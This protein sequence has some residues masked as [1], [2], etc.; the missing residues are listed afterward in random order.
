MRIVSYNTRG[1]RTGH[2]VADKSSRY[3]VDKLLNEC[4][5]LCLQETWLAKQDLDNLNS[6]HVDFHGAGESTTDLSTRIVRGRIPGGVAILWNVKYD[7]AVNV[8]RLNVDWAVGLEIDIDEKKFTILNVYMPYESNLLEDEFLH[9]LAFIKAYIEDSSSTCVFVMGDF[10]ADLS[11]D[12]SIFG[13]HLTSYC[14]ENNLTL[15]SKILLPD[16]SFTYISDAWHSTSWLDHCI[17]TADA[18][19]SLSNIEILYNLATSDHIPI[20]F[21]LNVANVPSLVAKDNNDLTD[22][23]D[24]SK[25]TNEDINKY[26]ATTDAQLQAVKLPRDALACCDPNCKNT[27]HCNEL[28]KLYE[29]IVKAVKDSSLCLQSRSLKSWTVKPGWND[30]VAEHHAAARDAFRLWHEAGK[31]R[32]GALFE[33]KKMTTARFKYSLRIIKRQENMMRADSLARGLQNNDYH[34]FW[35]EVNAMNNRKTSLPSNIEGV[36]GA[37]N[38][39][40]LWRKHYSDL[41]NSVKSHA[42]SID[43]VD[44]TDTM[45]I[46]A[47]DIQDAI[48]KIKEGKACGLDDITVEHLK[49][50]SFKLLPLLAM[51][52]TGFLTHGVLPDSV[53]SVVLIP[54]IKDKTASL[55]SLSNYRPIA[56]SSNISKILEYVLLTRLEVHLL[57]SEN[58]FGFKKSLGTDMCIYALQE[59]VG[60]Y[61]HLNTSVFLCFIDATKAFD[62]VNHLKLFQKLINRGVPKY[63]VRLLAFWYANQTMVV[64]WGNV[65]SE[66]FY[67]SNG[68]QQGGILSPFLFNV[69]IHDLSTNLNLCKT[70]CVV[71]CQTFNHLMYADD[72]VIFSPYSAGLQTLL[73]VCSDYGKDFDIKYNPSKSKVMIVRTK[74]DRN[75]NFPVLKLCGT[76]LEQTSSIK[77]LGRFITDDWRDDRDIQRQYCKL[78]AQANMLIRKFSACSLQVKCSLFRA[79]CTPLYTAPLWWNYGR[80]TFHKFLVAYNDAFRLLLQVPRWYRASQLFVDAHIPTCEALLRKLTYSLMER[81]DKSKNSIIMSLTDPKRSSCRYT[82]ALRK[83]WIQRLYSF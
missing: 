4:D 75:V 68:V 42:V 37:D 52:F 1:L 47:S 49:Y 15:S 59:I 77:Y 61:L 43:K 82:S 41:L 26:T 54:V 60:K 9:K 18:H 27:T 63:L 69:Y 34:K 20:I 39:A 58:Q 45:V 16:T 7:A 40:D 17:C 78:Y 24:W 57:T 23:L 83:H 70:G 53:L 73:K 12:S 36:C 10:N 30:F 72:L 19:A 80:G 33:S 48:S 14:E 35:K 64:K 44:F 28:C 62:R 2:S 31:P 21:S 29:N 22:K 51:C 67:V 11:D 71:G 79:Y 13:N 76:T 50:S 74:D 25:V 56:L 3:V 81:L 6:L 5:V 8:V 66:P 55:N 46:R 38:I 32:Q 65:L